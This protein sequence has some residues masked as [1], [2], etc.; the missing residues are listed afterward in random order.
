MIF[1]SYYTV[2]RAALNEFIETID[3]DCWVRNVFT[4]Y[5]PFKSR[6]IQN[7]CPKCEN[8]GELCDN[9]SKRM[10]HSKIVINKSLMLV[11][12]DSSLSSRYLK[13]KASRKEFVDYSMKSY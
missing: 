12:A 13:R 5:G 3:E 11:Q 1:S 4:H 2:N 6:T 9:F 7:S 10:R 8:I